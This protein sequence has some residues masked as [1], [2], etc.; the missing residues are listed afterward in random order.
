MLFSS[1]P[2]SSS[3]L[4]SVLF[5]S[6]LLLAMRLTVPEMIHGGCFTVS[7]LG[8]QALPHGWFRWMG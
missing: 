6:W 2:E 3:G 7:L 4:P 1:N 8:D 5:D